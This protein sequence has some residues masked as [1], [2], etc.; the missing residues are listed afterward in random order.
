MKFLGHTRYSLFIPSSGAWKAS[1]GSR[2]DTPESYKEYL[3][4]DSR[5]DLRE[6]I[7]LGASI[8]ALA[9]AA[10]G[11]ELRHIVSYS[12]SLPEKRKDALRR[13][14]EKYPFLVLEELPDGVQPK[15]RV[16]TAGDYL[17]KGTLFGEYRLDDDDILSKDYFER[18][19]EYVKDDL[20]GYVVSFPLGIE[21]ILADGKAMNLREMHYPMY[22]LG[23]LYVCKKLSDGTIRRPSSS[24]HTKV[25]RHNPTILDA[26]KL[27][28]VRFNHSTQDNSMSA[29]ADADLSRIAASM[30]KYPQLRDNFNLEESFPTIA[31]WVVDGADNDLVGQMTGDGAKLPSAMRGFKITVDAEFAGSA[32]PNQYL[33]SFELAGPDGSPLPLGKPGVGLGASVD[34]KVGYFRYLN[35]QPGRRV[36]KEFVF[37]PDGVTAETVRLVKWRNDDDVTVRSAKISRL[38]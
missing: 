30:E 38:L 18:M 11:F 33:L 32:S 2:F 7:F 3:Y 35:S 10:D 12:E 22:G 4:S 27:S 13:A 9:K 8:P 36:L 16:E 19:G 23:L 24:S 5:M 34:P 26:R 15:D 20:V 25:D 31:D 28:Y 37:L 1:N 29:T 14:A 21:A 6:R 17:T